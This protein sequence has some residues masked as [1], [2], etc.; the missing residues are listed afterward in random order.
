IFDNEDFKNLINESD[1]NFLKYVLIEPG[2]NLR[3][4]SAHG[5][6]LSI[7]NFSNANLLF[8]CF[9]RILKYL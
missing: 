8:L 3:N 9:F 5:L 4:K 6:D 1:Y 2:L 7:Y